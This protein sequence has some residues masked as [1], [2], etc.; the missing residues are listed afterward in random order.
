MVAQMDIFEFLAE[1]K[2][3]DPDKNYVTEEHFIA[4]LWNPNFEHFLIAESKQIGDE[5]GKNE[6]TDW[7]R[8]RCE[9]FKRIKGIKENNRNYYN[10]TYHDALHKYIRIYARKR[11]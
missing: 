5:L 6:F 10:P 9:E 8:D 3:Y 7:Q 1:T 2:R 11:K 4:R